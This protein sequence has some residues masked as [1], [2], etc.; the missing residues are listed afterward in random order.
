MILLVSGAS[1]TVQRYSA[2]KNL[3]CLLTPRNGNTIESMGGLPW[4]ADNDC[5]NGFDECR[6]VAMLEKIKGHSPIFVTAPDVVGDAPATMDMFNTWEPVIHAYG[7]PVAFV[8]QDGQEMLDMPWGRLDAIFIGGSTEYKLGHQ[9][10]WLV[11]EAKFR[12]KW[13]HMGRVN[14]NLRLSYARDIGCDSADGTGY[15]RFPDANLPDAL[16]FLKEDQIAIHF[17][18]AL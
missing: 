10:R 6:F 3:G 8:L 11:R 17:E 18:E 1:K 7:L 15:S 2:S 5:F 9:V 12:K 14:S 13:V 16:S 4:A